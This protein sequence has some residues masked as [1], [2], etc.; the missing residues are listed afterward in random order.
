VQV[1][2]GAFC[3]EAKNGLENWSKLFLVMLNN[4]GKR[5]YHL[6]VVIIAPCLTAL[7]NRFFGKMIALPQPN[8][9]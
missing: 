8:R 5:L 1:E 2:R 7:K 4:A 6:M 9:K 3:L